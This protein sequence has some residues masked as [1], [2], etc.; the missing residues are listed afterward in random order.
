MEVTGFYQRHKKRIILVFLI[1][2]ASFLF[3][4]NI[5]K[6]SLLGYDDQLN[7]E[8]AKEIVETGDWLT[9]HFYGKPDLLKPPLVYWLMAGT[10][11][12]FGISEFTSRFWPALFGVGGVVVVYLLGI[13]LSGAILGGLISALVLLTTPHFVHMTQM[14]KLDVPLMFFMLLAG[15]FF[16][17]G[18]EEPRYLPLFGVAVGLGFLTKGLSLLMILIVGLFIV[19]TKRWDMKKQHCNTNKPK[20]NHTPEPN[21]PHNFFNKHP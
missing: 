7:A 19:V 17:K 18:L 4:S 2:L 21:P 10:Y 16:W 13:A 11:H 8:R 1:I 15:L 3:F 9:I 20:R 14:V 12:F 5:G 6:G